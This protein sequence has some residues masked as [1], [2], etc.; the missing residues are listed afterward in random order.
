MQLT[1]GAVVMGSVTKPDGKPAAGARVDA[2][3][4]TYRDGR[5]ALVS[6]QNGL[7]D[8]RGQYRLFWLGPGEY[9]IRVDPARHSAPSRERDSELGRTYFPGTTDLVAAVRIVVSDGVDRSIGNIDLQR[10]PAVTVSGTVVN[11]V[12]SERPRLPN[13]EPAQTSSV[14][15]LVPR[16][17]NSPDEDIPLVRNQIGAA[18]THEFEIEGIRPGSYDLYALMPGVGSR[19]G[20]GPNIGRTL[21]EIGNRNLGGITVVIRPGV[22]V[23]VQVSLRNG[24]STPPAEVQSLRLRLT[25]N[26]NLPAAIRAG[27]IL[28]SQPA[29]DGVAIFSNIPEGYYRLQVLNLP[30]NSYVA[31]ILQGAKSV[32]ANGLIEVGN[33]PVDVQVVM[34]DGAGM[35]KGIVLNAARQ[36]VE[37][38]SVVLVPR[39]SLRNNHMLF[40]SA[41][42]SAAGTFRIANIAPGDYKLFAWEDAPPTAWLNRDYLA[43]YE[44]HG[45][46]VRVN[47]TGV[48]V[49][50]SLIPIVNRG[51]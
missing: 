25:S 50:L 31:D 45:L 32:Y 7:T 41:R 48:D 49:Q 2:L 24:T 9:F 40:A 33:A 38:A 29:A 14:F 42:T 16:G 34:N 18:Q 51:R 1:A 30:A 47:S 23:K 6:A 35:A 11:S 44:N 28:P 8:D 37:N 5:R 46:P 21:L 27:Y 13:G 10:A 39:D 22:D 43:A 20:A 4:L 19:R 12:P 3:R 17:V 26:S 36:P 15:Y